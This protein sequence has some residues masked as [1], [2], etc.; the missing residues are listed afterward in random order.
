MPAIMKSLLAFIAITTLSSCAFLDEPV[1]DLRDLTGST[2]TD[3][4]PAAPQ[5][6][7][8]P[9]AVATPTPA[10]T[11]KLPP[12]PSIPASQSGSSYLI[13]API[14]SIPETARNI[15]VVHFTRKDTERAVA[16][17]KALTE[18]LTLTDPGELPVSALNVALWPVANDNAGGNC[19][20]MLTDYEPIDITIEAAKRVNDKSEGPFLLTQHRDSGKRMIY[21]MSFVSRSALKSAVGE[22]RSLMGS[23]PANWPPYRSAK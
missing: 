23:D 22:W 10:P 6:L 7:P 20:E 19:I 12:A 18:T 4:A 16:M 11:K 2:P 17:C 1:A 21:D 15:A 13:V 3:I 9:S 5:Q 8:A 14:E